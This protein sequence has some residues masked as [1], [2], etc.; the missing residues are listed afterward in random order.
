VVSI[1]S[2]RACAMAVVRAMI[3]Q[4]TGRGPQATATLAIWYVL[5]RCARHS[6]S[7]QRSKN[8]DG[9][10][11]VDDPQ[12]QPAPRAELDV[13]MEALI[14]HFQ[15]MTEAFAWRRAWSIR[16]IGGQQGA[17][18]A[19]FIVSDDSAIPYRLRIAREVSTISMPSICRYCRG[20]S[21]SD[22][23]TS[24]GSTDIVL[25]GD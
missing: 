25:G 6:S 19:T 14:H 10:Y 18:W 13:S 21:L 23:V 12:G 15:L 7:N 20:H 24:I 2:L 3:F 17:S 8:T 16:R 5:K 1:G 4:S 11:R 9:L 22:V